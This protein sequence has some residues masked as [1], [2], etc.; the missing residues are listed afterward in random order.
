MYLKTREII[1][2]RKLAK[3]ATTQGD[4]KKG[5]TSSK[6]TV[7]TNQVYTLFKEGMTLC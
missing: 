5:S 7:I 3:V 4:F 1:E 2:E 6:V